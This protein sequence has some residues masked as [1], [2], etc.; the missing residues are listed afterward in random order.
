MKNVAAIPNPSLIIGNNKFTIQSETHM[1]IMH[2]D[3]AVPLICVGKISVEITNFNGPREN[4]KN[5]RNRM[6]QNSINQPVIFIMK[7][8]PVNANAKAA[9]NEPKMYNGLRPQLSTLK[10][11]TNVKSTF[12]DPKIT[13]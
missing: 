3:K 1:V 10:I 7:Q 8:K 12:A 5:K 2:I 13:W 11:A 9:H 6:M 4:A